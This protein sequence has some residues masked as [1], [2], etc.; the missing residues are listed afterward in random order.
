MRAAGGLALL[1]YDGAAPVSEGDYIRTGT[2]R[3][4]LVQTVRV[5]QAG[6]HTGRQHLITVVMPNDHEP[7]PDATV[8]PI[9]WYRR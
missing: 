2:G 3:M 8:H 1:Y 6:K 9:R 5:Q 7:E 4:Y